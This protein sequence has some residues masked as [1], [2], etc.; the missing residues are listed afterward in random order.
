MAGLFSAARYLLHLEDPCNQWRIHNLLYLSQGWHL[1]WTGKPLIPNDFTLW[2][3][4]P[5]CGDL[6]N[7]HGYCGILAPDMLPEAE[8][9]SPE[10]KETMAIV[11]GFY[12]HYDDYQLREVVNTCDLPPRFITG[13]VTFSGSLVGA[14]IPKNEIRTAFVN[15]LEEEEEE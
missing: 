13:D 11:F 2:D 8:E 3:R 5:V 7:A 1:A 12:T 4:G 6:F 10:E 15:M 9:P 14:V